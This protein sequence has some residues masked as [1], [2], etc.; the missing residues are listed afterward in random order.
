[1]SPFDFTDEETN[2]FY[3]FPKPRILSNSYSNNRIILSW[4]DD[5]ANNSEF[6]IYRKKSGEVGYTLVSTTTA[7]SHTGL[8]FNGSSASVMLI[9]N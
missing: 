9:R 6:H 7:N 4:N 1:M 3:V 8:Y 2:D 5:G